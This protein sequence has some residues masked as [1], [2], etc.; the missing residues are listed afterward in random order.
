MRVYMARAGE[1]GEFELQ[2]RQLPSR[3]GFAAAGQQLTAEG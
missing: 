1:L 3:L 2:F